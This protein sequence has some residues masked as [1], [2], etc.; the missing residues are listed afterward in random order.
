[1]IFSQRGNL[2]ESIFLTLSIQLADILPLAI[3][4]FLFATIYNDDLSARSLSSVIGFGLRK[5]T[6]V[7][8]K[9]IIMIAL[10][11]VA[12]PLTFVANYGLFAFFGV[13]V[14]GMLN[15]SAG[16]FMQAGLLAVAYAAVASIVVFGIQKAT[17]AIT[18]YIFIAVG[19]ARQLLGAVLGQ[20]VV[21][22]TVGDLTQYLAHSI[23]SG[24][25]TSVVTGPF[26]SLLVVQYVVYVAV[27][28]VIS[29]YVF[30]KKELEF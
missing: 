25:L 14:G 17:L 13:D 8:S 19:L 15:L 29:V 27:A 24:I 12:V 2:S 1:M 4:G 16:I 10:C 6:I 30:R 26:D 28:V 5:S 22:N 7:L 23:T 3:G 20:E 21:V 11:A 18:A 9:L